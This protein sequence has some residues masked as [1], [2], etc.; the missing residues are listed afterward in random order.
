LRQ[1]CRGVI[2]LVSA[3]VEDQQTVGRPDPRL[4]DQVAYQAALAQLAQGT[5]RVIRTA[6]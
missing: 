1:Q 3:G 2:G 4:V 5:V 6:R